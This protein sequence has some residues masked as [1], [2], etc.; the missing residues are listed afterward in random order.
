MIAALEF[1]NFKCSAAR[2]RVALGPHTPVF[3][4]LVAGPFARSEREPADPSDRFS[5]RGGLPWHLRSRLA[6]SAK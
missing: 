6:K 2:Q 3:G 5:P 1:G 4:S